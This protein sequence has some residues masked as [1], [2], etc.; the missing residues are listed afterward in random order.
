V[1]QW[2]IL[3]SDNR[4]NNKFMSIKKKC[5]K[6][7]IEKELDHFHASND[8]HLYG[9]INTC[10]RCKSGKYYENKLLVGKLFRKNI[11]NPF[12]EFSL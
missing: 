9:T 4:L 3:N 2:R 5:N 7:G 12:N 11:V 1:A 8:R 6:C 10:K